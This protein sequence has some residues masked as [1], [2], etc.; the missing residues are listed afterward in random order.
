MVSWSVVR[1]TLR[2]QMSTRKQCISSLKYFSN[3]YTNRNGVSIQ[4]DQQLLN[5]VLLISIIPNFLLSQEPLAVARVSRVSLSLDST[6]LDSQDLS[7]QLPSL[8]GSNTSSNNGS[9]NT[10][11]PTQSS[12]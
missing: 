11:S 2:V 3:L 1:Q 10:T 5:L 6:H 9:G 7:I 12:L 8:I 4:L